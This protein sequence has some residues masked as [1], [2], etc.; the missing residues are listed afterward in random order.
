M[1]FGVI[2]MET[3]VRS[4]DVLLLTVSEAL[5]YYKNR[6]LRDFINMFVASFFGLNYKRLQNFFLPP[7]YF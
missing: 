5:V 2:S 1:T 3:D 7:K 4:S 6:V